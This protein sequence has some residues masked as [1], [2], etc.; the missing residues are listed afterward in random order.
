MW[1]V[2]S[3]ALGGYVPGES[4]V[5]VLVVCERPLDADRRDLVVRELLEETASCPARG[6]ELTVYQRDVVARPPAGADF[7][8]NVNGGPRMPVAIHLD[9]SVEPGFWYVVDRAIAH[10]HGVVVEGPPAAEVV[11]DVARA[12]LLEAM[13]ASTRWHRAHEGV[14]LYSVLNA[15]R[16][17]R[18]AEEDVHGSK[19]AG[20]AW[21][22]ERWPDA[23]VIDAAVELRH[24]RPAVLDAASVH[25]LLDHVEHALLAAS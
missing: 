12:A 1:F 19:L 7:E 9:A 23:A 15:C 2:G 8:V 6:L 3:V 21:A 13:V 5:D 10:R 17:W 24:G 11:A 25:A 22:R 14:T 20:A 4:D 18:F 16:A